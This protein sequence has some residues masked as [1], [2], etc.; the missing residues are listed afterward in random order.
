[1]RGVHADIIAMDLDDAMDNGLSCGKDLWVIMLSCDDD[2]A[3]Y[4]AWQQVEN[5]QR[6]I[7][8]LVV[9]VEDL[10]HMVHDLTSPLMFF[11]AVIFCVIQ[12][13]EGDSVDD[14]GSMDCHS[15]HFLSDIF[16]W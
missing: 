11:I 6:G 15:L 2:M 9:I 3:S 7:P 14:I 12:L 1:M 16:I 5:V 4:R 13:E 10:H 8:C